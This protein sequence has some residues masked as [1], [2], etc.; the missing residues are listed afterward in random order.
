MAFLTAPWG[1]ARH[2]STAPRDDRGFPRQRQTASRREKRSSHSEDCPVEA[3][4]QAWQTDCWRLSSAGAY[5]PRFRFASTLRSST[6]GMSGNTGETDSGRQW[7][8]RTRRE[9]AESR[10]MPHRKCR[11]RQPI[12]C[13]RRPIAACP[14]TQSYHRPS[15]DLRARWN[16]A[17]RTDPRVHLAG[18]SE[19]GA[20]SRLI[21]IVSATSW[22]PPT[23]MQLCRLLYCLLVV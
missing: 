20:K 7:Q 19:T 16:P 5:L 12:A 6:S 3:P 17:S 10:R 14:S 21:L 2:M 9:R 8:R 11:D 1:R 18:A 22:V 13:C 23:L 4:L 15:F